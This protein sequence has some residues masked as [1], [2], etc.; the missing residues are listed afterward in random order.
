MENTYIDE[1]RQIRR[2]VLLSMIY[3]VS[4]PERV[5]QYVS[6]KGNALIR[7]PIRAFTSCSTIFK[8]NN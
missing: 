8:L 6:V 7:N 3:K 5:N 4:K 1:I 2:A